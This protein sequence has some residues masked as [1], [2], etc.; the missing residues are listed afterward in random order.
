MNT[1]SKIIAVLAEFDCQHYYT[2]D[3]KTRL[4]LAMGGVS[5]NLL[6]K[7]A[8]RTLDLISE[9]NAMTSPMINRVHNVIDKIENCLSDHFNCSRDDFKQA[10]AVLQS[11]M[12]RA[13]AAKWRVVVKPKGTRKDNPVVFDV[14]L[15]L[16]NDPTIKPY[17]LTSFKV[18]NDKKLS[19]KN[20][21]KA[22]P[23][24]LQQQKNI[25]KKKYK[26]KAVA[27]MRKHQSAFYKLFEYMRAAS[28]KAA[29]QMTG[30]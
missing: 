24:I 16:K 7:Y 19:P 9:A 6:V 13:K 5:G 15:E 18:A 1:Q 26:D 10:V 25:L 27:Y 2:L 28:K 21:L 3:T 22:N 14:Y 29:T 23:D 20:L 12:A 11:I 8:R 17:K 4:M 30:A